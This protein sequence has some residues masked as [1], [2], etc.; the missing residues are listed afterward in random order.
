MKE[1]LFWTVTGAATQH[2]RS[3]HAFLTSAVSMLNPPSLTK[4][5][6]NSLLL[7]LKS[8]S[9]WQANLSVEC[10]ELHTHHL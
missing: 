7:T 2:R 6:S 10:G 3:G 4:N 8:H 1:F 9:M 5:H